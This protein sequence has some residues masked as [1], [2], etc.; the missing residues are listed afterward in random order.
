MQILT[1]NRPRL[2]LAISLG[3]AAGWISGPAHADCPHLNPNV[4]NAL[5]QT[6]RKLDWAAFNQLLE[7]PR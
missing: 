3:F 6:F 5:L 1:S 2:L 4:R 7:R